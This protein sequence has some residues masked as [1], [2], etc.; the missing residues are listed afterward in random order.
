VVPEG[1]EAMVPARGPVKDVVYQLVGGL[2]SGLSYA[3]SST[4]AELWENAEF[5]RITAA[6]RYESGA[7]DVEMHA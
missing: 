7:H 3:G 2:R 6:G 1:V 4:I 5:V